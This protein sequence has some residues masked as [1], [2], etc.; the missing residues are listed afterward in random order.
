MREIIVCCTKYGAYTVL[1]VQDGKS[2]QILINGGNA[3]TIKIKQSS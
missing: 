2:T 3:S 1:L